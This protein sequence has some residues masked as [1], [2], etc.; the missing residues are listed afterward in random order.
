[1]N[2]AVYIP[3][4]RTSIYHLLWAQRQQQM[5]ALTKIR[6]IMDVLPTTPAAFLNECLVSSVKN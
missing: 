5:Q 3:G 1:M 6:D 4:E 2:V